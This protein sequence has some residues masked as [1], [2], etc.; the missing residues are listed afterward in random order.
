MKTVYKNVSFNNEIIDVVIENGKFSYIGKTEEDGVDL[1][2]LKILPGLI[3]IHSHG[4]GGYDTMDGEIE[5]MSPIYADCGTTSWLPTT[6][7]ADFDSLMNI[8]DKEFSKMTGANML[9]FHF[10]GP[11][12][13]EK[14]KGAQNPEFISKPSYE[15]FSRFKNVKMVTVAPETEGGIEFIKNCECIVSIGHTDADYDK[16]IEAIES[17]ANC[18]THTFNAMPPIHHREPGVI[19]AAAEKNIYAQVICDGIHIHKGAINILYKLFG[20]DRMIL[21]SDS[22]RATGFPDGEYD[23]GGLNVFVRGKEARLGD[24]TL[25]GS[26]STLL[27]CVKCAIGFGIPEEDAVKMATETPAKLLGINKG[28][29]EVGYDADFITVDND[30]ELKNVIIS[31]DM[32]K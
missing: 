9:G 18:L 26:V 1:K 14:Y 27:D 25:A 23:L 13:S 31:G 15:E 5:K 32:Y 21:I 20:A 2:G 30:F 29:I 12:I 28:K 8:T 17:G 19:G 24:G 11:Y 16:T 7:T 4:C 3:D 22:M 6:M 10:E